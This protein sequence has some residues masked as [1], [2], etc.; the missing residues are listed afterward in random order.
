MDGWDTYRYL[1]DSLAASTSSGREFNALHHPDQAIV[2][3]AFRHTDRH[4]A[5]RLLQEG[6][7]ARTLTRCLEK[8]NPFG[9][10]TPSAARFRPTL[11]TSP[12]PM[13]SRRSMEGVDVLCN[14]YWIR[15]G[16]GRNTFERALRNSNLLF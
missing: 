2:T 3:G 14:T 11:R 9:G 10:K 6:V 4:I 8:E 5:R 15:S 7:C 13:A 16:R 12:T 1:R